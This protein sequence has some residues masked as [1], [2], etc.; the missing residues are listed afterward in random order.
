MCHRLYGWDGLRGPEF[1][2][3][4]HNAHLREE[5]LP[6]VGKTP[7]EIWI[8]FGTTVGRAIYVN[9]WVDLLFTQ[10][11]DTDIL[12][13][14]DCRFPNEADRIHDFGGLI[15]RIDRPDVGVSHDV[16][17]EALADYKDWDAVIVNDGNLNYLYEQ[18][19]EFVTGHDL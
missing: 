17:D 8:E 6:T 11:D 7:R 15:I 5:P 13:I 18:V 4:A 14:S 19:M 12:L 3:E 16:A 2:E 10:H 9:T 1:Y